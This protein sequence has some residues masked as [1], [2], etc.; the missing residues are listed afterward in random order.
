MFRQ[1]MTEDMLSCTFDGISADIIGEYSEAMGIS[2]TVFD[3]NVSCAADIVILL[4]FGVLFLV[5]GALV[6]E[7]SRKTDR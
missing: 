7:H 2:L 4:V 3:N 6:T 5:F 1:I